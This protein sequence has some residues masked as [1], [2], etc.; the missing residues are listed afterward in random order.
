[1]SYNRPKIV[2]D[3]FDSFDNSVDLIL[4]KGQSFILIEHQNDDGTISCQL[5]DQE[6]K[7]RSEPSVKALIDQVRSQKKIPHED[8]VII[9]EVQGLKDEN[10][11]FGSTIPDGEEFV[12]KFNCTVAIK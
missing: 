10:T 7:E 2:I 8:K 6:I 5:S 12:F 1:M 4:T 11:I 3:P 9:F